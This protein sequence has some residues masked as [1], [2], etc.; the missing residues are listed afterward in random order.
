[1]CV[2]DYEVCPETNINPVSVIQTTKEKGERNYSCASIYGWDPNFNALVLMSKGCISPYQLGISCNSSSWCE[3]NISA[4]IND[5][6]L[7][8][9]CCCNTS[10]C[11]SEKNLFDYQS[12]GLVSYGKCGYTTYT[13]MSINLRIFT[14]LTNIV[15][16]KGEIH[17]LEMCTKY[18]TCSVF[19]NLKMFKMNHIYRLITV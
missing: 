7:I 11:N 18:M 13:F 1:M 6:S 9:T 2:H 10:L 12:T 5:D 16:C 4:Y 17:N 8:Y 19:Y 15:V 3:E 14:Y